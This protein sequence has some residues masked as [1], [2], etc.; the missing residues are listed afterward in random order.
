VI[1]L[2]LVRRGKLREEYSLI[3]LLIIGLIIFLTLVE[4]ATA[5]IADRLDIKSSSLLFGVVV[6]LI[7][8]VQIVQG[9]IISSLSRYSRDLVQKLAELDWQIRQLRAYARTLEEQQSEESS[10]WILT[11]RDKLLSPEETEGE[12][13]I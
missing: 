11:V 7:Y 5:G 10:A 4:R 6:F 3:F 12:L 13:P 2:E 9:V 1:V 8:V